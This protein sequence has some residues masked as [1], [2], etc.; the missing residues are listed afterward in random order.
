MDERTTQVPPPLSDC[1]NRITALTD[2]VCAE[3]LTAEFAKMAREL[4][5]E[6]VRS[7][8]PL[9]RGKAEGWAAG[10]LY[11]LASANFLWDPSLEPHMRTD[12]LA[13]GVGVSTATLYKRGREVR[14]LLDLAD[15]DPRWCVDSRLADNPLV[16]FVKVGDMIVDLRA[17]SREIQAAAYEEGLIPFIPADRP[18]AFLPAPGQEPT[19]RLVDGE[20]KVIEAVEPNSREGEPAGGAAARRRSRDQATGMGGLMASLAGLLAES[21]PP[22]PKRKRLSGPA[23]IY[24]LKITLRDSQPP[25][26]RRFAVPGDFGL[27]ELH[28]TIQTVM[29][30][31][32]YHL[33]AFATA[34]GSRFTAFNLGFDNDDFL[35]EQEDEA[36]FRLCDVVE[37]VGSKLRYEYDFGDGWEHVI[38]VE[39]IEPRQPGAHYPVCLK[40]RGACPPEDCGGI[41]GYDELL[42]VLSDP[43]HERHEELMEWTGGPIDPEAFDCDKV[44][45]SLPQAERQRG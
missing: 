29:G 25:I 45:A 14:D 33:H 9:D 41:W 21:R 4:A 6:L 15:M 40:G 19:L 27:D 24:V 13:A 32:D 17:A 10:I 11:G 43:T 3:R 42:E 1:Y 37:G 39:R 18:D 16:W 5:L 22:K 38:R 2:R 28:E 12:E 35:A 8:A 34:D 31:Q 7:K 20:R 23:P 30:W 36:K 26:W 44:N